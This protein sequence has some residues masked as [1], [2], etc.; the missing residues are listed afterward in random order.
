MSRILLLWPLVHLLL[1][2]CTAEK[3]GAPEEDG[4]GVPTMQLTSSAFKE[5]EAI[6]KDFTGDGKNISPPL[7]WSGQPDNAKSFALIGDDPDA[8]RGTW[9]HWVLFNVPVAVHELPQGVPPEKVVLDSARQGT[10]D[11]GKIGYGG[12]AP[13]KGPAHHYHFKLYALDTV[14]ELKEG[15]TKK[16]LLEAM[17]GHVLAEGKLIG[18]YGR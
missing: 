14:L 6:P 13:P 10:N 4:K 12:P 7:Q 3:P 18:T 15:A 16:Q 2:G 1:C 17:K 11:F 8:P 9:V 5:G